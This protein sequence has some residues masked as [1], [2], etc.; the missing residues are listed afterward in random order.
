[1]KSCKAIL[2]S[3]ILGTAA[4]HAA[5]GQTLLPLTFSPASPTADQAVTAIL[6]FEVCSWTI[7]TSETRIDIDWI[8][9]PCAA[10]SFTNRIDLGQL[11]PGT[12][13]VYLDFVGASTPP[14]EQALGTLLVAPAAVAP[15]PILR[16]F[17]VLA[18]CFGIAF[19]G[20]R[21]LRDRARARQRV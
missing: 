14:V 3:A 21:A 18:C 2:L 7:V 12:Y 11:A 13:A 19:V 9:A 16:P 4:I 5:R 6:P 8:A 1:M 20:F 10:E 17:G 15:L